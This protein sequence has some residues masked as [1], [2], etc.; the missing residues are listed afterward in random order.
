MEETENQEAEPSPKARHERAVRGVNALLDSITIRTVT[1]TDM[2]EWLAAGQRDFRRS[3]MVSILYGLLVIGA[4]LALTVGLY[5]AGFKH[6]ILSFLA[7]F[8]LVG[9]M[10]TVGL[11]DISHRMERGERASL[12]NA[13]TAWRANPRNLL[14]LG[15]ALAVILIVWIRLTVIIFAIYFP[16]SEVT[17]QELVEHGLSTPEGL[18]VVGIATV[19]GGT[20]ALLVFITCVTAL[21]M[22]LDQRVDLVGAVYISM[23]AVA[24]NPLVMAVWAVLIVLLAAAGVLAFYVGLA[25]VISVVG[26]ASWHAYRSIIIYDSETEET[27]AESGSASS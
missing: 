24:R 15:L 10:L 26:H 11:Y 22:L 27:E 25:I 3:G 12:W 4:G 2:E 9:P 19:I 13:L 6:M 20:F 7:G 18:A 21:P 17:L 16:G 5:A 8:L 14:G 23:I 1:F